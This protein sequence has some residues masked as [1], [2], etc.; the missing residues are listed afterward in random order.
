MD[1]I[2][3]PSIR[4]ELLRISNLR[5]AIALQRA[6]LEKQDGQLAYLWNTH[7]HP[8]RLPAEV[9]VEIFTAS[10][11]RGFIPTSSWMSL[12]LVCR[13][14]D[15]VACGTPS[16]WRT[17][18][19]Y[20][21]QNWLALCLARSAQATLDIIFHPA[22]SQ[23]PIQGFQTSLFLHAARIRSLTVLYD[24]PQK[25]FSS[26]LP[27]FAHDM[28][29]LENVTFVSPLPRAAELHFSHRRHPHVRRLYLNL[30]CCSVD[31]QLLSNLRS[32][33]L[34][35]CRE[36]FRVDD[37][38]DT[39]A[40]SPRLES[41]R[42]DHFLHGL[43][44]ELHPPST[45]LRK[46]IALPQL[47]GLRL[48]ESDMNIIST[49]TSYLRL[50]PSASIYLSCYPESAQAPGP[51]SNFLPSAAHRTSFMPLLGCS[52]V[53]DASLWLFCAKYAMRALDTTHGST[54]FLSIHESTGAVLEHDSMGLQHGVSDLLDV[55]SSGA[56]PLTRLS[57]AGLEDNAPVEVWDQLSTSFPT[58][59][60]LTLSPAG[61]RTRMA[62]FWAALRGSGGA[63]ADTVDSTT[64]APWPRL[65]H[66]ELGDGFAMSPGLFSQ[67]LD[68]LEWRG[69][70]GSRLRYLQLDD[71]MHRDDG[72]LANVSTDNLDIA[73]LRTLVDELAM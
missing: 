19:V 68:C 28:P 48:T 56:A 45:S 27:L 1:M 11:L 23:F 66:L 44:G 60:L 39:L 51:L 8:N 4:A 31:L 67:M 71:R 21:N 34:T 64:V 20:R 40:S 37:F 55:L 72:Q 58:L 16:L 53:T 3:S 2:T 62:T 33:T 10:A 13:H 46:P 57:I 38:F 9:L 26:L 54:L 14:W 29:A 15:E 73:R 61:S 49:F 32:L 63:D 70:R 36:A 69:E 30:L 65:S 12:R 41:L 42:L 24:V 18:D 25:T 7:Q 5:A 47:A 59:E 6:A 50:P 22:S 52:T 17:V 35:R 43:I